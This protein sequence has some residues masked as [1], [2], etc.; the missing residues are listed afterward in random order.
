MPASQHNFS[1]DQGTSFT[2]SLVNKDSDG[3]VIILTNYCA[4]LVM[5]SNKGQTYIFDTD[6]TDFSQ[7]K[8]LVEGSLGKIT[9]F[10][11][12]STTNSY[13]FDN[14]KYD[15]ELQSPND[16]YTGGGKYTERILYGVITLNKRFSKTSTLLD[17]SQ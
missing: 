12:A 1:I 17:C 10:I 16:H 7:Y 9:L 3:N 4:R 2:L 11:P 14:A 6:N 8:F 13:N 15:L 5:T